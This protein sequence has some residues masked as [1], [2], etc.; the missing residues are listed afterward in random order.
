MLGLK[1]SC[2]HPASKAPYIVS[3]TGGKNYNPEPTVCIYIFLLHHTAYVPVCCGRLGLAN[4]S[5]VGCCL[6]GV[7]IWFRDELRDRG[8]L[9]ILFGEG[10][11]APGV[12]EWFKRSCGEGW[13]YGLSAWRILRAESE[14]FCCEQLWNWNRRACNLQFAC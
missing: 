10:P 2:V 8:G 11:G 3:A 7:S 13:V 5:G 9:E 4:R 6:G 12:Q 14:G 1:D